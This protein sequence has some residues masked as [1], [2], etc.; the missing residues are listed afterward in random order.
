MPILI[1][2][3]VFQIR[4]LP[5]EYQHSCKATG[6]MLWE[7]ARFLANLLALNS[8]IIASKRVLELG[9]GSVGICSIIASTVADLVVAS[10]G[11]SNALALL[12]DNVKSNRKMMNQNTLQIKHLEWGCTEHIEKVHMLTNRRGF[13]V[14]IGSDVTYVAEAVPL[15]F[16]TAKALMAEPTLG[17]P[18]PLLILCHVER[19][20]NELDILRSARNS[21]LT[22]HGKW[23]EEIYGNQNDSLKTFTAPIFP[24]GLG[25]SESVALVRTFCFKHLD[26][27]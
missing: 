16:A 24:D 6:L 14:I 13:D 17:K 11:D 4:T 10:D 27:M 9:C 22:L 20:V 23:P 7:S 2:G 26:C 15:L 5:K 19:H 18:D 21:G 25:E 12:A 3:N 8:Q 1:N